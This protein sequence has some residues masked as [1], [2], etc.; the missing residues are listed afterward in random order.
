MI[1]VINSEFFTVI[2]TYNL[3]IGFHEQADEHEVFCVTLNT[4]R[5]KLFAKIRTKPV[6]L[7]TVVVRKKLRIGF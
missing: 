4:V 5:I 6:S 1:F 3:V 7:F 2:V